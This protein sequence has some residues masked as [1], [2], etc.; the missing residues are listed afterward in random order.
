VTLPADEAPPADQTAPS[1]AHRPTVLIVDDERPIG[2]LELDEERDVFAVAREDAHA[3]EDRPPRRPFA[4]AQLDRVA[5]GH[6]GMGARH[7]GKE[8]PAVSANIER[9][10]HAEK[11]NRRHFAG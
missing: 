1:V 4:A 9:V 2:G 3:A 8:D 5:H 7:T 11:P 10:V 6:P